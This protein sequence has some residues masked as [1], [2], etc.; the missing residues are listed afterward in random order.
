MAWVAPVVEAVQIPLSPQASPP[1]EPTTIE[2]VCE[3]QQM[4]AG[5]DSRIGVVRAV[6]IVAPL[7]WAATGGQLDVDGD[8]DGAT[9]TATEPGAY[10]VTVRDQRGASA[11]CRFDVTS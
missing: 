6:N 8:L 2:V 11:Q 4:R 5:W 10:W 9:W 7:A 3:K 1:P